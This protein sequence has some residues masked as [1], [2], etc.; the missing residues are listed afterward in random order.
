MADNDLAVADCDKLRA[1]LD[2]LDTGVPFAAAS[3]PVS[4]DSKRTRS[5]S[6][7][8]L[9]FKRSRDLEISS[10]LIRAKAS[11][12][13]VR[14]KTPSGSA[15]ST[16]VGRSVDTVQTDYSKPQVNIPQSYKPAPRTK[17]T[18]PT[19]PPRLAANTGS[20]KSAS[21][22]DPKKSA[23]SLQ[24]ADPPRSTASVS[25][26][27]LARSTSYEH[28]GEPTRL[29]KSKR[30]N[31]LNRST[32]QSRLVYIKHLFGAGSKNF[33][34]SLP[35]KDASATS[36]KTSPEVVEDQA[37]SETEFSSP[38]AMSDSSSSSGVATRA[39]IL[40]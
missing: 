25:T 10:P 32:L 35:I 9:L 28:S 7:S 16:S 11:T 39:A 6:S 26:A 20:A 29:P 2:Q 40:E 33:A 27:A 31:Y 30:S 38:S 19:F 3:P 23:G 14:L 12:R 1:H 18:K 21:A 22:D 5:D 37:Y 17:P 4:L 36:S 8:G 13:S 24:T 15:R 34:N